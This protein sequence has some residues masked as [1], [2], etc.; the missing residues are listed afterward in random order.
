MTTDIG[1]SVALKGIEEANR[2]LDELGRKTKK[3]GQDAQ[4]SATGFAALGK[5]FELVKKAAIGF[6]LATAAMKLADLEDQMEQTARAAYKLNVSFEGFQKLQLT[7]KRFGVEVG[8]VNVALRTFNRQIGD[9][10]LQPM[11][12]QAKLFDALGVS[13]RD[14]AG[15]IRGTEDIFRDTVSA[16]A[17]VGSEAE[18]TKLLAA[19]FGE[20]AV[21]LQTMLGQGTGQLDQFGEHLKNIG[22]IVSEDV[23]PSMRDANSVVHDFWDAVTGQAMEA[24]ARVIMFA[25]AISGIGDDLARIGGFEKEKKPETADQML[26]GFREQFMTKKSLNGALDMGED[27]RKRAAAAKAEREAIQAAREEQQNFREELEAT[28]AEDERLEAANE[29]LWGDVRSMIES[30]Q[31]PLERYRA[32]LENLNAV[33]REL[34]PEQYAKLVD[35]LNLKLAESNQVVSAF[36]SALDRVFDAAIDG[37]ENFLDTLKDIGK[38]LGK[39]LLKEQ[40][41]DPLKDMGKSV[42]G[43]LLGGGGKKDEGG[44]GGIAGGLTGEG[45]ANNPLTAIF[46][47]FLSGLSGIFGEGEDGFLGGL[48]K[49]FMGDDGILGSLGGIFSEAW[50]FMS[51]LLTSFLSEL[52]ILQAWE[53]AERWALSLWEVAERWAIA[54]FE[55]VAGLF[56][57][58]TGGDLTV[59]RPTLIMV[60]E[61]NKAERV[62]VSPLGGPARANAAQ[63]VQRMIDQ[64]ESGNVL[65]PQVNV[66]LPPTSILTDLT[67]GQFARKISGAVRRENARLV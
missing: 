25:E 41:F 12:V 54:I 44:L 45:A 10:S 1:I 46:D 40:V 14:A 59:T 3:T 53:I 48:M 62:R 7:A 20:Q 28:R 39:T 24:T 67:A 18:K 50:E 37:G 60:G 47:T 26:A 56:G 43:G 23:A 29:A 63:N 66:Y 17:Q 4:Q 8:A 15:N 51:G 6:G 49:M 36:D 13:I 42:I 9:A 57:L 38:E 35:D 11:G 55:A 22:A 31:S 58:E 27:A 2:K 19:L 16:I 34:G 65:Q 5:Q 64:N 30:V 32:E 52:G 21:E 33:Y 61:K